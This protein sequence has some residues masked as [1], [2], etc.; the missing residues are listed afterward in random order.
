[1]Q[2]DILTIVGAGRVG[3][4][5]A[6]CGA[7]QE[8]RLVRR[9]EAIKALSG[10]VVVC[11]RNDQLQGFL[12]N[13]HLEPS[14]LVFVQNGVLEIPE[15][16]TQGILY[17]AAPKPDGVA[18]AGG[19]S[20]FY[21]PLAAR[22]VAL[23]KAGGLPA[24]ELQAED[25]KRELA[26]KLGWAVVFGLLGEVFQEKVGESLGRKEVEML[27]EELSLVFSKALAPVTP[28]LLIERWRAYSM[29]IPHWEA[30][31][32]DRPWRNGWVEQQAAAAG[33]SCP[34]HAKLY[35]SLHSAPH[36]AVAG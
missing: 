33:I 27:A 14:R 4:V 32:K 11:V 22:M 26:I 20:F 28:E 36:R 12:E 1:M 2:A 17:F 10:P 25:F 30:R 34:L 6:R 15:G 5:L 23:L 19:T 8:P 13:V 3:Q 35:S 24:E 9:G 7:G 16:S 18:V 21:G 29:G 31:I